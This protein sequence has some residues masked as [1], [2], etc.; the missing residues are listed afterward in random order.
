MF[1]ASRYD[2]LAPMEERL[3]QS[4]GLSYDEIQRDPFNDASRMRI[5]NSIMRQPGSESVVPRDLV[6]E[7]SQNFAGEERFLLSP[8]EFRQ[9]DHYELTNFFTSRLRSKFRSFR[10][11]ICHDS[12]PKDVDVISFPSS[13]PLAYVHKYQGAYKIVIHYGLSQLLEFTEETFVIRSW[14][15]DLKKN[16]ARFGSEALALIDGRIDKLLD[17]KLALGLYVQTNP[18][19]LP[20]LAA[21]LPT[22][23]L[24]EL[25]SSVAFAELFV[26]AHEYVHITEGHCRPVRSVDPNESRS[27]LLGNTSLSEGQQLEVTTDLKAL[28]YFEP[29][30]L[31]GALNGVALYFG[32]LGAYYN[33]FSAPGCSHPPVSARIDYLLQEVVGIGGPSLFPARLFQARQGLER[34]GKD[35]GQRASLEDFRNWPNLIALYRDEIR[36]LGRLLTMTD[37]MQRRASGGEKTAGDT[38]PVASDPRA[39]SDH[40]VENRS[41]RTKGWKAM[42]KGFRRR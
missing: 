36:E 31:Q 20:G 9:V 30:G 13:R 22:P 41:P 29:A 14:I 1:D 15:N 33:L 16:E 6:D 28:S 27:V 12:F 17:R 18:L 8:A 40:S 34:L 35:K 23:Y 11:W 25:M 4:A 26:C 42:F 37:M 5:Y 32:V 10:Q 38:R 3:A 39:N 2:A 19:L 24:L 7:L 21:G